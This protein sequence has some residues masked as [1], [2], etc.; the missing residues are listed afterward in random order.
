LSP[1]FLL[2]TLAILFAQKTRKLRW[3]VQGG[4]GERWVI[5]GKSESSR[6]NLLD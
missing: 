5:L 4:I 1:R 6:E 2:A 3:V